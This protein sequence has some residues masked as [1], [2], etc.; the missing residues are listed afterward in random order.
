[1]FREHV[2][3]DPAD[4]GSVLVALLGGAGG[5]GLEVGGRCPAV[6]AQDSVELHG[7]L[8]T[9]G[10]RARGF[11]CTADA[12]PASLAVHRRNCRI[13]RRR[14]RKGLDE[15]GLLAGLVESRPARAVDDL[16]GGRF[17]AA[18]VVVVD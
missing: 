4:A 16:P 7:D 3:A 9:A 11:D 10:L 13:S 14:C 8:L 1:V 6:A 18:E 12:T 17:R 5:G 15:A 2:A